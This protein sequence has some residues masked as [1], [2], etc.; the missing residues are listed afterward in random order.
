MQIIHHFV[1]VLDRYFGNVCELDLIFNFHKVHFLQA[2]TC[3]SQG[4]LIH[5]LDNGR[6]I[7]HQS[8]P[9]PRQIAAYL[10]YVMSHGTL[11]MWC[12]SGCA[13][14]QSANTPV[15]SLQCRLQAYFMLDEMLLAGELQEPSKKAVTRVIEVQVRHV[16]ALCAPALS[17]KVR[18]QLA[19]PKTARAVTNGSQRH[20]HSQFD[21]S[22]G[23]Q[24]C[25]VL[26]QHRTSW[27]RQQS[28]AARPRPQAWR[29]SPWSAPVTHD[30]RHTGNYGKTHAG[31]Q[32]QRM[33]TRR[34]ARHGAR[35]LIMTDDTEDVLAAAAGA[36]AAAGSAA[37]QPWGEPATRNSRALVVQAPLTRGG[38]IPMLIR[39]EP[40]LDA[41]AS[42][43]MVV[44]QH[45]DPGA[46]HAGSVADN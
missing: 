31:A 20:S 3:G 6:R 40:W 36:P 28:R 43:Q 34:V 45:T 24:R 29:G 35:L 23:H 37:Q 7:P 33:E 16:T 8:R 10:G 1:E 25:A 21:G 46:V 32:H 11:I 2:S 38:S 5:Q 12:L 14:Y 18:C 15:D 30:S 17:G 42:L 41:A 9:T 44:A 39:A 26:L 13:T 22:S 19:V 27:W 4:V